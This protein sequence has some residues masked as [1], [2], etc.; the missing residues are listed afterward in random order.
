MIGSELVLI[1]TEPLHRSCNDIL[2]WLV[3]SRRKGNCWSDH[4][5]SYNN[6]YLNLKSAIYQWLEIKCTSKVQ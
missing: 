6:I 5:T 1:C 3:I 2:L 4:S